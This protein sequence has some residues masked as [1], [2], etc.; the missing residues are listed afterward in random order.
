MITVALAKGALLG[1]S[2]QRFAAAGLDFHSLQQDDNRQLMATSL[3]GRARALLVRNSDVPV[4]VAYGQAQLGIVGYDVLREHKMPVA[5]LLDL[6]FGEC[7]MAVAVK[8][9]SKYH[10]AADLPAHCRIASKFTNCAEEYFDKLD[11]PIEL[12]HLTGSVE[13]GPLTGISEAIVDLVASGRTL[14]DNGLVPIED[15]F[16]STA[17][18]IGHPLALRLDNGEIQSIVDTIEEVTILAKKQAT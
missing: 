14:K 7:R 12:I 3:C 4:Y 11:L 15:L 18:L 17:R 6:G 8:V 10:R 9:N 1:D 2:I 16:T 13:L 5:Q